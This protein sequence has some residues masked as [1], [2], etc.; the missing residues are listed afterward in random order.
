MELS[1]RMTVED[2]KAMTAI[3]ER[4]PKQNSSLPV[5]TEVHQSTVCGCAINARTLEASLNGF[6][7]HRQLRLET[8]FRGRIKQ[9]TASL[10][11]ALFRRDVIEGKL[12]C[13][14]CLF[15]R[16]RRPS[17]QCLRLLP[18]LGKFHQ[19]RSWVEQIA[20]GSKPAMQALFA[21]HRTS[22]YR[23]LLRFV[24]NETLAQDLLSEVF[25][26]VAPGWP[27]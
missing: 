21:R 8:M 10:S 26:D 24:S 22:V 23:W 19:M 25:L 6:G 13:L 1:S 3:W 14:T 5:S 17:P 2:P 15:G 12:S 27:I 9:G 18:P 4:L 20:A 16:N 11:P 7:R